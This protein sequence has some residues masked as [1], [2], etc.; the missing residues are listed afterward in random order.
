MRGVVIFSRVHHFE[1]VSTLLQGDESLKCYQFLVYADV[2]KMRLQRLEVTNTN[3]AAVIDM[4][5]R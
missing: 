3:N 4:D 5:R 2:Q 1:K